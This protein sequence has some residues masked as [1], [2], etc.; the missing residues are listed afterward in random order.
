MSATD[1]QS[2]LRFLSQEAKLPLS[3]AL[4]KVKELQAADLDT[5]AK[6]SKTK[7]GELQPIF[8]DD[9]VVK[10]VLAAA[11]RVAKKR[12]AGLDNDATATAS[13]SKRR[14]NDGS[15]FSRDAD[16]ATL[17]PEDLESSLQLPESMMDADELTKITLFTNRAPLA[18]AFVLTLLTYT[19][20]EQPL[21][22]RLSLAQ[23]YISITSRARAVTL[24]IESGKSAEEEGFGEGTASV[25]VA[26]K[27]IR[28]L[29]RWGYEWKTT[30]E[31]SGGTVVATQDR[32][33]VGS[34]PEGADDIKHEVEE[35]VQNAVEEEPALWA[36]DL[37]AL[38]RS[39]THEPVISSKPTFNGSKST[40]PIYTPQS[41][42][43]YLL[44]AFDTPPASGDAKPKKTSNAAKTAEK[45]ENLGKL[46]RAL[47]LLYQSWSGILAPEELDKR[48]WG[49]YVKV[50]PDVADGVA[51]WGGK[52]TLLLG[53]ILALRRTVEIKPEIPP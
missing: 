38:K 8:Q 11:K 33:T 4:S 43:T 31:G 22:S 41:A 13:P 19:M 15:F 2:L 51:G 52:N 40:L 27:K 5:E 42:R 28:V 18:L 48:T 49:W 1:L 53:S 16:T 30:A 34:I 14:K 29:R 39:N 36:L 44:K 17:S 20:P 35:G 37:E 21:S 45:A 6:I 7:A 50:R 23:G 24:G 10:Q 3:T 9:K 25:V 12:A 32:A 26:G 47:D 46:L